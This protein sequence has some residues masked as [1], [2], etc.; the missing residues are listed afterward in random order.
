MNEKIIEQISIAVISSLITSWISFL[1]NNFFQVKK[2]ERN[3]AENFKIYKRIEKSLSEKVD[4]VIKLNKQIAETEAKNKSEKKELEDKVESLNYW[5]SENQK[6]LEE[7]RKEKNKLANKKR[8]L[9]QILIWHSDVLW[10]KLTDENISC[11][12]WEKKP[13]IIEY[14]QK[15]K[16]EIEISREE[17]SNLR[18]QL[19]FHDIN[20]Q[21][22][23][24]GYIHCGI[25]RD[26]HLV[27]DE[28]KREDAIWEVK[29]YWEKLSQENGNKKINGNTIDEVL[30]INWE[31][32]INR[33][34]GKKIFK[35]RDELIEV[36]KKEKGKERE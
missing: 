4:E 35:K 26:N 30:P 20:E 17:I 21:K 31:E 24:R 15:V 34:E 3:K 9:E 2:D 1:I 25:D 23:L 12:D 33:R 36:I 7:S 32:E 10:H 11:S 5:Y 27:S 6:M 14:E 29:D 19:S 8:Q 22:N 16:R 28:T 13:E 18:N